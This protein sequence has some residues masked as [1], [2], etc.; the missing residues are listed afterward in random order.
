M[1]ACVRACVWVGAGVLQWAQWSVYLTSAGFRR[2]CKC[3][4]LQ[5]Q[6]IAVICSVLQCVAFC[7]SVHNEMVYSTST[8]ILCKYNCTLLQSVAECCSVLQC[9]AVCC[10][11]H[12]A[13]VYPIS[14]GILHEH[15]YH[16]QSMADYIDPTTTDTAGAAM[17]K[18]EESGANDALQ[19]ADVTFAPASAPVSDVHCNTLQHTATHCS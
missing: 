2:M 3:S 1:R 17:A 13:V 14:A 19:T 9:V 11:V 5:L 10:S 12:N 18:T 7:C 8:G 6:C 16:G 4:V 15:K